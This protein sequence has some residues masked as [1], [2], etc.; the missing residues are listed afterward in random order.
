MKNLLLVLSLC[1]LSASLSAIH[2][3]GKITDNLG[4][5]LPFASIYI[6]GTSIGT[7]SNIDGFYDLQLDEG[8]Y[9]IV[10][11]YIGYES[12]TEKIVAQ[13]SDLVLDIILLPIANN[14]QEIVITA[15]E[16]PAYRVIR[17]AIARRK[18]HLEQ[19]KEYSCDSYVKGTQH[20]RNLPKSFMGQSLDMFRQGLDSN[21][22]GIIYLSESV[23]RLHHKNGEFKEIM[24]SSKVSGNDNGFSFN[25]GAALA[26][27]N[28]YENSFELGDSKILSPIAS[29][30][31]ASY[32]YRM[33]TTF[34][35]SQGHLV[36][37]IEVIPKNKLAAIFAGYI[38]IVDEEWAI[39]STD[40]FTTGKSVN[41][42]VLDT[43]HFK[44]THLD[45]GNNVWRIFTQEISF[46]LK[47]LII[48]T[49]GKFVGVFTNYDLKPKF[50][51]K[52]FD[53]EIFKVEDLANKKLFDFWD[54]IRPVPLSQEEKKE[55]TTKDSLQKIW[56][57]RPY[58]DSMDRIANKFKI[59]DILT[60]YT[61]QNTYN[62]FKF[63]V[64]SPINTLHYNTV[65]GQIIGIG[66]EFQKDINEEKR[67]WFKLRS[68]LEYSIYDKQLR[69]LG[70]FQ[71][72]LNAI[73]NA[74]LHLEGG[75]MKRQFNASN[76]IPFIVNTYYTLLGKLNYMKLYDE[77]YG[78]IFYS[79]E[80][81]NGLMLRASLKYAQ[82]VPLV[83][84]AEDS[85][86]PK[87]KNLFFS[88]QPLDHGKPHNMKDS[89]SFLT[90]NHFEISL[91]VRIRFGQKYITYPNRRF[92]TSSKYP[93]IWLR[94]R[95]G[96]PL[97]G[98][99]T[100]YDYLELKV[101]KDD[102]PLGTV[103][104][105]SFKVTGGWFPYKDQMY[106]MDYFH[107][108][109]N[110]TFIAKT[111]EYLNTFQLLPYYDYSTNSG[112]AM[113]HLQHDFNGF[114]WNKIP[115]LKALGFEFVTGYHFLYTPEKGPYME[116]NLGLDRIGWNLFRF[117]R[118]DFVMGYKIGEPLRYGGVIGLTLSL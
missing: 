111:S 77:Y 54:S 90:H 109:G 81:V 79:Q 106:F 94:Y 53:A 21:G 73:N 3:R 112:F 62:K 5:S 95:R 100:N 110:Q 55:Y 69:G 42:S 66:F 22:T 16:D 1:L 28:F 31:L 11:Q 4:E 39:H 52:F 44:Q 74:F 32:K 45:L 107:F 50:E 24:S 65:Q 19:V 113:V 99:A 35:D 46:K 116:F 6:Q 70:Q 25:S 17:K 40:L 115:G 47:L 30:A 7:T 51:A 59:I 114:I 38:Y 43:V 86:V 27:I 117:L 72:Q 56:E 60:G 93:D 48:G 36:Y 12:K 89:P 23:S 85:W 10:F 49:E 118:V 61:F 14:L 84:E 87:N 91:A 75:R 76:P 102:I 96:I 18:F 63:T 71:V 82:R 101:E 29:G 2:V 80:L 9:Q 57:S 15:G 104:L 83:N 108:N 34:F 20:V 64:L 92:Y 105:F 8:T 13:K 78:R 58:M 103:G 37:K 33:E 97:L 41:I 67:R 88:N 98:G 26:G 68:E